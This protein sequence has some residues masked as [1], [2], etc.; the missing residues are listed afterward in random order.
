MALLG[1][2]FAP[3]I[4]CSIW[5]VRSIIFAEWVGLKNPTDYLYQCLAI[6]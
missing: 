5:E 3:V 6:R 2:A 1:D 4:H